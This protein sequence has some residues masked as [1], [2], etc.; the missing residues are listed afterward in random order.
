MLRALSRYGARV[1]PNTQQLAAECARRGELVEGPAIAAFEG[2]FSRLHEGRTAIAASYGRMAFFYILKALNLPRGSEAVFPALTFWVMPEM[3]RVLGLRPVFADVD[4]ATFHLTPGSLEQALTSRTRVVVPTHLYGLPCDMDPILEIARRRGLF[5]VEDCAH[6]LGAQYQGRPV[7][8]LGDAAIFSFQTLKPL[9][10]YGGGMAVVGDPEL[11]RKVAELARAE[12]W[13]TVDQ[14]RKRLLVG[15]IQRIAIRP[16]VFPWTLFPVLWAASFLKA[17][18]DVYL[19]EKIRPLDPLPASYRQRY[20]NV[21]AVLGLEGLRRLDQ[22][23]GA[24]RRNAALWTQWL[25]RMEGVEL[26]VIPPGRTHVYYQYCVYVPDRD[27]LVQ[28]CIRRGLDVET[29]HVDVCTRLPL[30]QPSAAAP[31]ADRAAQAVQL[32]VYAGLRE[33]QLRWA[34][35]VVQQAL[36]GLLLAGP[37]RQSAFD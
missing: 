26:P 22:W 9:N 20:S 16:D 33:D 30:F 12:P 23:T 4:P 11:G 5:V 31:G 28:R 13:P 34:A 14:V 1:L 36:E 25:G 3:A 19:W 29:L 27:R 37:T 6:A 21:Q 24:S 15:R 18:P 7:G 8:V 2:A 35:G 10:T 32:P 17:R